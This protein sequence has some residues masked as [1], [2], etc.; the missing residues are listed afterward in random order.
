MKKI[1]QSTLINAT[2][3]K[4]KI[5]WLG[6]EIDQK[7]SNQSSLRHRPYYILNL[8]P[9]SSHKQL[10][11]FLGSVHHLTKFIPNQAPLCREFGNLLQKDTKY[12]WT[13]HHQTK[14]ENIKECIRNLTENTHYDTKGKTRVKTDAS[15]T[16]LGAVLEQETCDGW[17]TISY[18]SR[19]LNK[20]EEKY[21]LNELELLGV[22]WALE[23][24]KHYLLG[25]HFIVQTDHRALLSI[26][27]E[28]SSKI[29]QSRLT[30]WYDRLIPFNFTIEHI[31][32]TKMGLADYMSRNPSKPAK[33]Q[34]TYDENFI[35]AQIDVIK[36][37]LQILRKRG[38]PKK[39][40]NNTTQ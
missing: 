12:A 13:N 32:G 17:E 14:L 19:F 37:T 26:L 16:G 33:P 35:I 34:S 10:K 30:R 22:V 9:P 23:H 40:N 24:F 20:A 1:W 4:N 18:A 6:Y 15:R 3:Q 2:S 5:T 27:K 31:A 28:R 38:R 21:S 7:V 39:H 11:P 29:H 36:E 25:H 8:K